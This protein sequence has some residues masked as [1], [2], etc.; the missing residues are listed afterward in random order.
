MHA[1]GAGA[2]GALAVERGGET[3]WLLPQRAA[4]WPAR[5]WLLLA[6][7]HLGKAH[8]FRRLGVPVPEG[9][10]G[11]TL[12][13]LDALL[14]AWRP[15]RLVVLGDFLHSA[16]A[17][18]ATVLDAVH[19]WREA[20]A[21]LSITLVRGNHD[22]RAGDPPASLRID[23]VDEP[24]VQGGLALCHHPEPAAP[25]YVLAGHLHPCVTVGGRARD[26]LRRPC[27]HLGPQVGVLPAF[28]EFTGMHPVRPAPGDLLGVVGEDRVLAL[29][30]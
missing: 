27:F 1:S 29:G 4:W 9:T 16:H 2:A 7:V 13:R 19:A 10:T 23:L 28:G 8:S 22:D 3:L 30:G 21:A 25:H 6:D 26:H 24:W 20:H 14:Q 5:R 18:A 17:Q 11:G 15:E 12:A